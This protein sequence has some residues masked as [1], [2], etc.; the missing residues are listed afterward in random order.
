M[1]GVLIVIISNLPIK[2]SSYVNFSWHCTVDIDVV[3]LSMTVEP[4]ICKHVYCVLE[5]E[6]LEG[7][8]FT[9]QK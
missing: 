9:H 6:D 5:E 4:C 1:D 2:S 7:D 8:M 3:H